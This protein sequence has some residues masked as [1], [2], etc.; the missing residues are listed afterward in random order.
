MEKV[1]AWLRA[2]PGLTVAAVEWAIFADLERLCGCLDAGFWDTL[3][4]LWLVDWK[5][6]ADFTKDKEED[7]KGQLNF[8]RWVL[9]RYY[10][11]T[12]ARMV[13]VV[14]HASHKVYAEIEVPRNDDA[15]RELILV[16]SRPQAAPVRTSSQV[17]AKAPVAG[18]KH[19]RT[20]AFAGRFPPQQLSLLKTLVDDGGWKFAGARAAVDVLHP[21]G[22]CGGPHSRAGGHSCRSEGCCG[23]PCNAA[24]NACIHSGR[25]RCTAATTTGPSQ[26]ETRG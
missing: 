13:V 15:V 10:R 17:A 16:R 1:R 5:H 25:Q 22:K 7:S 20:V 23:G 6:I 21:P 14:V 18:H 2:H 19:A 24:S 9:E 12:I 8:Y 4:H 11:L 3:G 26:A